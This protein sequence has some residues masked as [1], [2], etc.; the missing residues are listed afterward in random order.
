MPD[1]SKL[2]FY[3]NIIENSGQRLIKVIDDIIDISMIQSNQMTFEFNDFH[4][5]DLLREVFDSYSAQYSGKIKEIGFEMNSCTDKNWE[6][7]YSD[8][9]KVLQVLRNL[10]DN[11]FKFT[12]KGKIE[13]GYWDSNINNLTLYV[14][15][16][17]IGIVKEKTKVIFE[18]FRQ[19]EE[20]DARKF[21]GSGLGLAISSAIMEKLG[22]NI[23]LDTV[24]DKGSVFYLEFISNSKGKLN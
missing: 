5:N 2:E 8:K 4:L 6:F 12:K 19:A 3:G 18:P 22:G 24:P 21:E 20:G 15:D 10:L 16:T 23:Q 11:A 7:I 13:F 17:G 14:K 1:E 9:F